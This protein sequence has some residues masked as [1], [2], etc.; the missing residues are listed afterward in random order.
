MALISEISA[1]ALRTPQ[2]RFDS[3]YFLPE[4]IRAGV[5]VDSFPQKTRLGFLCDKITQGSNPAFTGSGLPCLNGKNIR[6]GSTSTGEPNYVS[7]TEF[8]RLKSYRLQHGDI[9]ITLKHATKIGRSW[10]IE[11]ESP[12]IFSRNVGLIRLRP[13]APISAPTL[14]FYLW[15]DVGQKSLDRFATGGTSGQITL[16]TSYLR[17][18]WVPLI[19]AI[20]QRTLNGFFDAYQRAIVRSNELYA[21]A[22]RILEEELGLDKIDLSHRVGYETSLS[23]TLQARRWDPQHY[24]PKYKALLDAIHKAPGYR[25]LGD[26]V[27][28]NLRGLQPEYVPDGP[29]A[30][31]NSQHIGPQHLAY[32]Q[33]ERTSETAFASAG[34]AHIRK[35]DILV[36]TTGAY[37]GRTNV[38]LEET[39]AVASNHVNIVRLR[40]EY[41][42]A[43]VGLVLNS[44][45]GLLQTEKHATG[46]AQAELYPSA[47]AKFFVPLLKP[48]MMTA[49]GDKV[50]ASYVALCESRQLLGQA[51]RRVE[52]LIE[53]KTA[54]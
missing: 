54:G 28:Y 51:K 14:L 23:E 32:D 4:R 11:D 30:V 48:K 16:A 43:Y 41:D 8:C 34:R 37:V 3:E 6:F 42:A 10:I 26:M 39:Q 1:T 9:V 24:R 25:L 17:R 47:I 2:R 44:S 45:I 36:Y 19:R 50:R 27:S 29:I 53:Q 5:F 49:I 21:S 35:N 22:H 33:F 13:D 38:F 40:P 31:V 52:E 12:C 7:E 20:D 15:S 18:M 46:S